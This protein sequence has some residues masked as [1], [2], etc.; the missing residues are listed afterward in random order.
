MQTR[1]PS[2]L[3]LSRSEQ[4]MQKAI[5][6][7]LPLTNKYPLRVHIRKLHLESQSWVFS[8][9]YLVVLGLTTLKPKAV[10]TA[11]QCLEKKA[12]MIQGISRS[13]K[14]IRS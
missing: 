5:S 14:K 12:N 2:G 13:K 1:A 11:M 6:Y 3:H 7:T 10:S 4:N 9:L 8:W